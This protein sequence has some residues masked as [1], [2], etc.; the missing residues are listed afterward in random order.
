MGE[1]GLFNRQERTYL[2][3]TR[4]H[5]SD[6]SGDDQHQKVPCGSES[7]TRANHEQGANHQHSA[8]AYSVRGGCQEQ[9]ND[10]VSDQ[11]E[12]EKQPSLRLTEPQPSKVERQNHGQ[13]AVCEEA[14]KASQE[15]Q[16]CVVS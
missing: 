10:R 16:P 8:A 14:D 6:N 3:A 12:G 9:G 7:Q 5:D 2:V 1:R 13:R 15:K 11:R 4:T